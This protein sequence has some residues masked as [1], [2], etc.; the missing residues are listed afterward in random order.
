MQRNKK[1]VA[2]FGAMI[3][4]ATLFVAFA[5]GS[6]LK[7]NYAPKIA[8][9][10]SLSADCRCGLIWGSGCS[11]SNYGNSCASSNCSGSDSECE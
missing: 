3:I 5:T 11:A 6:T 1:L 10:S 4:S 7:S 2:T 8:R 9:A